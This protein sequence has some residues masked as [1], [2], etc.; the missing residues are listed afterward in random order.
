ME[1]TAFL[2]KVN[3][4]KGI[5]EVA[6]TLQQ[7]EARIHVKGLIGSSKTIVSSLIAAQVPGNHLFLLEDKVQPIF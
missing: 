7:A 6:N 3:E 2:K 1:L 4:L 5:D